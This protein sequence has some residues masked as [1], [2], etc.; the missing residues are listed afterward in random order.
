MNAP[1]SEEGEKKERKVV[2]QKTDF[3][4][5]YKLKLKPL[6]GIPEDDHWHPAQRG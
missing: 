5:S 1:E 6:Q 2:F 4:I 3:L